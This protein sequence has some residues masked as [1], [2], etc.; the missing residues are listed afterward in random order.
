MVINNTHVK[1]WA[2]PR[3][4]TH[5]GFR[6]YK[7][8]QGIKQHKVCRTIATWNVGSMKAKGIELVDVMQRKSIDIMCVQEVEWKGHTCMS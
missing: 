2:F 7:K 4:D 1:A 8:G 5:C 6:Q 3:G